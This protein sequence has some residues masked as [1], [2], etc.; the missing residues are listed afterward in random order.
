MTGKWLCRW[1]AKSPW[2]SKEK[3]VITKMCRVLR[4]MDP[5]NGCFCTLSHGLYISQPGEPERQENEHK[6]RVMVGRVLPISHSGA[7]TSLASSWNIGLD[8]GGCFV[9]GWT[10]IS[11]RSTLLFLFMCW[12]WGTFP[13]FPME[14]VSVILS[15]GTYASLLDWWMYKWEYNWLFFDGITSLPVLSSQLSSRIYRWYIDL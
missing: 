2:F 9:V 7:S 14:K 3:N 4:L 10:T 15:P 1:T 11:Y 5:L 8:W 6:S 12:V 13:R